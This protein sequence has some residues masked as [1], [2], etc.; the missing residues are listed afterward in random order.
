MR[1]P[2]FAQLCQAAPGAL[3]LAR[4]GRIVVQQCSEVQWRAGLGY[5]C[6]RTSTDERVIGLSGCATVDDNPW[7]NLYYRLDSA[8]HGRGYAAEVAR[9]ALVAAHDVDPDR[10]VMAY[11]VEHNAA[12]RRIAERI[13]LTL[14]WRGADADN[15]DPEAIRLVYLDRDPDDGLRRAMAAQGMPGDGM[16]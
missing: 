8:V 5:W 9:H 4:A 3:A 16:V 7:W 13:G 11:L 12:S 10:P 14:V 2:P 15:E 6:V 1:Q